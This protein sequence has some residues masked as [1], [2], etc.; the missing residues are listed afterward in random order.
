MELRGRATLNSLEFL[1]SYV[2]IALEI[3]RHDVQPLSCILSQ[4]DSTSTAG[5]MHRSNFGDDEPLQLR[6][7]RAT[8]SAL[9]DSN[10][11][12]YSQWIPGT[13][14]PI[15]DSLSRDHHLPDKELTSALLLSFPSQMPRGFAIYP[16]PPELSSKMTL[17]L[18]ALPRAKQT[19]K[20]PNRSKLLTGTSGSNTSTKSSLMMTP[21]SSSSNPTSALPSQQ[22]LE[23]PIGKIVSQNEEKIHQ[24]MGR[25][26]MP[27][28]LW[29]RPLENTITKVPSMMTT[30]PGASRSDN[31]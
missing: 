18:Q 3:E 21:S 2:A 10:S 26:A 8:A 9:M 16:I 28:M 25:S 1:A 4:T 27:S 6:I 19:P 14:N 22:P 5:W 12:V 23:Q 15:A 30:A 20:A 13:A 7:A 29:L 24:D 31:C 11:M 17:W